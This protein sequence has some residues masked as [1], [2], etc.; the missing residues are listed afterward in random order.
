VP[1]LEA[2]SMEVDELLGAWIRN[3]R[4][5]EWMPWRDEDRFLGMEIPPS[6]EQEAWLADPEKRRLELLEMLLLEVAGEG[7]RAI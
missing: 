5:F 1:E 3:L 4:T 6:S 7:L 2:A